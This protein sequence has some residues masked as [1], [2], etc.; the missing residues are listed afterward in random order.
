LDVAIR[1]AAITVTMM[2]LGM[3][4][5]TIGIGGLGVGIGLAAW[6]ALSWFYGGLFETFWNGQTPGKWAMGIRVVSF[7][8]QPIAAW[9]AILRNV[10]REID[11]QP[12]P[13]FLIGLGVAMSNER[14][15]RLGDL[16]C[17]TMVV[18]EEPRWTDTITRV[19]DPG[20]LALMTHIPRS[21]QPLP[22]LARA[23]AM[24]VSRREVLQPNRRVEV[25][26]RLARLFAQRWGL[27]INTD[28]DQ[29]LVALYA[30]TFLDENAPRRAN[31]SES[32]APA[33]KTVD[34]PFV[35]GGAPR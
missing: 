16:V 2:V 33:A 12:F 20:A 11:M 35:V 32:Y 30:H 3:S 27:P 10:A 28:P 34:N 24:Y 19:D 15:Q 14:F 23:L 18:V 17:G 31:P 13:T 8:G 5:S 9:Q 6:F 29:L 26:A 1:S 22:S 4:F 25:A 21:Y 7:D